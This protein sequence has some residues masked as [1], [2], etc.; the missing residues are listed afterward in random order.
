MKR[1]RQGVKIRYVCRNYMDRQDLQQQRPTA[2]ELSKFPFAYIAH[3]LLS[4]PAPPSLVRVGPRCLLLVGQHHALGAGLDRGL[5]VS[6]QVLQGG[7]E[8]AHF[9]GI[10]LQLEGLGAQQLCRGGVGGEGQRKFRVYCIGLTLA[11]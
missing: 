3:P 6:T 8:G 7:L 2:T 5:H 4:P 11:V 1:G 9:A 10:K